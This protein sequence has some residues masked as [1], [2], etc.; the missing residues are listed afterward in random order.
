MP[1]PARSVHQQKRQQK[2]HGQK[3][4]SPTQRYH[5]RD[6][7]V[8]GCDRYNGD[9]ETTRMLLEHG[10][11]IDADNG[12]GMTPLMFAVMFGR[13]KVAAQLQARSA[14]MQRHNRRGLSAGFMVRLSGWI[15]RLLRR[16][17][18]QSML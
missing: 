18:P 10:A 4:S 6:R 17:H 12:G 2:R 16:R 14:S 15:P 5:E 8:T 13:V 9:L 7:V 3:P 1:H 11:D